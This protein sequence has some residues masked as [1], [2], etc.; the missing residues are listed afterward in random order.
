MNDGDEVTL[1]ENV[2]RPE[3]WKPKDG[4]A[5]FYVHEDT[6]R[7]IIAESYRAKKMERNTLADFIE[8]VEPYHE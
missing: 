3:E 8:E 5:Q 1:A 7:Q 2:P 4:S 6:G